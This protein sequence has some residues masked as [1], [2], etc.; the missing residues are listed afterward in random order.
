M[1]IE[2][3]QLSDNYLIYRLYKQ[4]HI[5][6]NAGPQHSCWPYGISGNTHNSHIILYNMYTS[7]DY[8]AYITILYTHLT[9]YR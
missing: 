3:G 7:L 5:D 1:Y 8:Q 9:A 2:I 6:I 4:Q